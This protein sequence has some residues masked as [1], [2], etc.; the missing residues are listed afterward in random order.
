MLLHLDISSGSEHVSYEAK[1]FRGLNSLQAFSSRPF[2]WASAEHKTLWL[3]LF[4]LVATFVKADLTAYVIAISLIIIFSRV[5][6]RS[7]PWTRDPPAMIVPATEV[8]F[9]LHW[10]W[11]VYLHHRDLQ[12]GKHSN[13]RR[14]HTLLSDIVEHFRV[15]WFGWHLAI[16][17]FHVFSFC[18]TSSQPA[19]VR[20]PFKTVLAVHADGSRVHLSE[21]PQQNP[22]KLQFFRDINAAEAAYA[23]S[24]I[25]KKEESC[26]SQV[27][28]SDDC[29][30]NWHMFLGVCVACEWIQ[31]CNCFLCWSPGHMWHID[32]YSLI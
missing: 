26:C 3:M 17:F 18:H 8:D 24:L 14:R 15:C 25:K 4:L 19:Q 31:E 11:P 30:S 13:I 10:S 28:G 2:L 12:R 27:G 1:G 21:H 6:A 20:R 32:A 22:K 23:E 5:W 29:Q 7:K 9:W 16:A